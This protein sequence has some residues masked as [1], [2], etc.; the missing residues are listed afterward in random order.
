LLTLAKRGQE[1]VSET[2]TVTPGLATDFL[3]RSAGNRRIRNGVVETYARDMAAGRWRLTGD[4]LRFN[5][6]GEMFDGHHRCLACVKTGVP[7]ET[8]VVSGLADDANLVIDTGAKRTTAN[9]LSYLGETN[10]AELASAISWAW[11]LSKG[12]ARDPNIRP[13]HSDAVAWLSENPDIRSS[14]QVGKRVY[15]V[16]R[17]NRSI[18]AAIHYLVWR[19]DGNREDADAFFAKLAEGTGLEEG[20]PILALRRYLERIQTI[21]DKPSAVV[22]AA[23][24]IKCLNAWRAGRSMTNAFWRAGGSR[25]EEFPTIQPLDSE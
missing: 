4:P 25:A 17:I 22:T 12:A 9:V 16:L 10:V 7:F 11:R 18:V 3:G 2:I 13:S 8:M 24:T 14:I 21:R 5:T 1:I 6:K 19:M 23:I 15:Q 20:S